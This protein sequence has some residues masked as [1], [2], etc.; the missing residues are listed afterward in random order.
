M[1]NPKSVK[2]LGHITILL[3]IISFIISKY[4]YLCIKNNPPTI[5]L[6]VALELC[7]TCSNYI[8]NNENYLHTDGTTQGPRMSCSY[9]DIAKADFDKGASEYHLSP[10]MWKRFRH[11]IFVLSL[12][13]RQSLVLSQ[14][15][16]NTLDPTQKIKITMEVAEPGNYLEFLNLKRKWEK[17]KITED[18]YSTLYNSFTYALPTIC[19]SGKSI[20]NIP[21]SIAQRLERVCD[22]DEKF[23]HQTSE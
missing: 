3:F 15:Y 10:T 11:D 16:I 14:D 20:N 2:K 9:A 17:G 5:F 23:K 1:I 22:S 7:L 21:H 13:D 12:Y 18:V 19:Y 4:L 8:F 6:L